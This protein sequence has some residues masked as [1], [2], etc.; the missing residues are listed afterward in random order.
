MTWFEDLTPYSYSPTEFP[1][2]TLA[3]SVPPL[4]VGWLEDD[5][6][7][8]QGAV[9]GA[10]VARLRALVT[11]SVTQRMRGW[12]DCNLCPGADTMVSGRR[13]ESHPRGTERSEPWE[14]TGLAMPRRSSSSTT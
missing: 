5:H 14:S 11:H 3:S 4:N 13:N 1:E 2:G 7:Y 8:P 10:F 6:S 9:P 12:Q